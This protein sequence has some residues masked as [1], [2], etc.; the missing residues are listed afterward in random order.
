MEIYE[1]EFPSI[2]KSKGPD[3]AQ[4]VLYNPVSV[5]VD[6]IW[7]NTHET[8]WRIATTVLKQ[9]RRRSFHERDN[10]VRC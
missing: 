8:K 9:R 3:I 5:F 7:D 1:C 10:F 4:A 6:G 2:E